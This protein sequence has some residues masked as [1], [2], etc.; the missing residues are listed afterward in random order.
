MPFWSTELFKN[1][2]MSLDNMYRFLFP[3]MQQLE[4]LNM[5]NLFLSLKN[6]YSTLALFESCSFFR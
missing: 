2:F 4:K 1:I 3:E 5:H 6:L